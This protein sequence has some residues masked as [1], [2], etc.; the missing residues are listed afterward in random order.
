MPEPKYLT[1]ARKYLGIHERP[2]PASDAF[3]AKCLA[4]CGYAG[5]DDSQIPWCGCFLAE[6][7]AESGLPY[8]GESAAAVSWCKWGH[9]VD[10]QVGAVVVFEWSSGGHHVAICTAINDDENWVKCLGGNQSNMVKESIFDQDYIICT[11]GL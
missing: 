5:E 11:R 4:R 1:Q 7:M 2:G 9:H 8:P 6:I 3:I 10:L